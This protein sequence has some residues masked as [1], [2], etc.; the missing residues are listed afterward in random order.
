MVAV[1]VDMGNEVVVVVVVV[2][3]AMKEEEVAA[4]VDHVE[5]DTVE[6]FEDEVEAAAF[7]AAVDEVVVAI[8]RTTDNRR[9]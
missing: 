3:L 7:A 2:H 9:C 5:L 4:A 8:T 1:R 6:G